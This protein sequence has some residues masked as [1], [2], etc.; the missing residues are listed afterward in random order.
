MKLLAWRVFQARY[1][2]TAFSG[3]G[4]RLY[5]GRWNSVGTAVVYA[6]AS[7]DVALE[8][9]LKHALMLTKDF[10]RAKI[11]FEDS[12]VI[13]LEAATLPQDWADEPPSRTT[14]WI[15]DNWV[16]QRLSAILE[17]PSVVAKESLNYLINPAHPDF[18]K[19]KIHRSEPI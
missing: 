4:A 18:S 1:R 6:S 12:L 9:T 11:E 2:K 5:G 15:G 10:L 8:E 14:Q 16:R 19:I 13:T 17:V 3:E 7:F